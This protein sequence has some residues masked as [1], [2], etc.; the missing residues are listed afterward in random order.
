M[1]LWDFKEGWLDFY[2]NE[3]KELMGEEYNLLD[4]AVL[5]KICQM[6]VFAALGDYELY[7]EK[8]FIVGVP[9][10]LLSQSE[11]EE[12]VVVQGTID[13]L[14]IGNNKAIIIDYKYSSISRDE[15]IREKYQ[16]QL[17]L[18]AYAVKKVLKLDVEAHL[19]NIYS[20]KVISFD[21]ESLKL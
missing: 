7:K 8:Q 4:K 1:E 19:V 15:D 3:A 16:K 6:Q 2:L 12:Q 20:Q 14:A 17:A 10:K 11:V 5:E 13:L 18:Y 9:Y 21:K